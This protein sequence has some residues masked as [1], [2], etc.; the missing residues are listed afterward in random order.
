M[1]TRGLHNRILYRTCDLS[2]RTVDDD[3]AAHDIQLVVAD[4]LIPVP[5]DA[6]HKLAPGLFAVNAS[7]DGPDVG[8][9]G[10]TATDSLRI[11][12]VPMVR[13][14]HL[15]HR[16][17]GEPGGALA[18]GSA[19]GGIA[20]KDG[21]VPV[22]FVG[23]D[24]ITGDSLQKDCIGEKQIADNALHNTAFGEGSITHKTFTDGARRMFRELLLA[25][26]KPLQTDAEGRVLLSVGKGDGQ[27]SLSNGTV[28]ALTRS[29]LDGVFLHTKQQA[30]L[31][32]ALESLLNDLLTARLSSLARKADIPRPVTPADLVGAL[33]SSAFA[34]AVTGLKEVVA[35]LLDQAGEGLTR[36]QVAEEFAN[37]DAVQILPALRSALQ[38]IAKALAAPLSASLR[39]V[40]GD[41]DAAERLKAILS[42]G[43]GGL[44]NASL[45]GDIGGFLQGIS[46][47]ATKELSAAVADALLGTDS[48]A[49]TGAPGAKASLRE[50]LDWM[51]VCQTHPREVFSSPDGKK[52]EAIKNDAGTTILAKRE[53]T[54]PSPGRVVYG[55]WQG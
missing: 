15:H 23:R 20:P 46:V 26:E 47:S 3:P 18:C 27:L 53:I 9:L 31:V 33:D 45:A 34:T 51:Y 41:D 4:L 37:A 2:G 29:D 32:T 10:T 49:P 19:A 48:P 43:D 22:F 24:A 38:D 21:M 12:V 39:D 30:A 54:E 50:R 55:K 44:L 42:D 25:G 5:A 28:S 16:P 14:D 7:I 1:A 17:V 52:W 11:E 36:V 8:F 40:A 35:Q 6:R 13:F